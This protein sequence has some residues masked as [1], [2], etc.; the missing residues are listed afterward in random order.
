MKFWQ[1]M[2]LLAWRSIRGDYAYNIIM[3]SSVRMSKLYHKFLSHSP[4]YIIKR[5]LIRYIHCTYIIYEYIQIYIFMIFNRR[6]KVQIVKVMDVP[7][8]KPH[9]VI[10]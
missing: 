2:Q 10:E 4:S 7:V 1:T 9:L 6:I 8:K 5:Y 3:A